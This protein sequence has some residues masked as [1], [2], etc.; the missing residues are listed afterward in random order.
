MNTERIFS[1][2]KT[3]S[4]M[5]QVAQAY[6]DRALG[7]GW[8]GVGFLD[9]RVFPD[10]DGGAEL[11]RYQGWHVRSRFWDCWYGKCSGFLDFDN[12]RGTW[13][14]WRNW[15]QGYLPQSAMRFLLFT[16][17]SGVLEWFGHVMEV[18]W[19]GCELFS[20]ENSSVGMRLFL[21]YKGIL[22][23]W[24]F[25]GSFVMGIWIPFLASTQNFVSVS[26]ST[27]RHRYNCRR[28]SL[29]ANWRS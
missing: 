8:F 13:I 26:S 14:L 27:M 2:G 4:G 12:L 25:F 22:T 24:I 6:C 29:H 3:T 1:F 18:S 17:R 20:W 28:Q 7:N 15:I 23:K 11:R 9:W 10:Y 19:Q 5:T 16:V 21:F